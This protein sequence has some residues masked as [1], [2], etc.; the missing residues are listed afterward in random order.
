M[1]EV[2]EM[3]IIGSG[4]AG[5]T[6]AVYAARG[7]L[8]PILLAGTVFGGQLMTT[9]VVENYPGFPEGISGPQLMLDMSKQATKYGM[10]MINMNATKVDFSGEI[11]KVWTD[12]GEYQAKTVVIASGSSPRKLG[13]PGEDKFFGRGV[14]TCAT[15][16]GAFF[17]DKTVVVIG[18]GDT[19]ME[20]STFLTKFAKK[21]Y[22]AHRRDEFRASKIMI[23]RAMGKEKIEVLWN[24]EVKAILGGEKVE[25]VTVVNN[26]DNSESKLEVDGVFL[27]IGHDPNTGF[28]GN[29]IELDE[30][31]YIVVKDGRTKTSV[32][33]VFVAGD[34]KDHVYQQ[35]VTAAGM[36][37]MAAMDAEKWL[38][39]SGN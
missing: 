30:N 25:G 23:E 7:E 37:C 26:K 33:G 19:A 18:G 24:T 20:D 31:G 9:G 14:S 21:V 36:G 28:L 3:I 13:I 1:N 29:S 17:K 4:P 32:E 5:L 34:V 16:D 35:A 11:K 15:C 27:A 38:E 10:E 8:K 12:E 39:I 6:A 22:I 2:R